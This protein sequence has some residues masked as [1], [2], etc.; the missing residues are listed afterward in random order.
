MPVA[1]IA[2]PHSPIVSFRIATSLLGAFNNQQVAI[3]A[4]YKDKFACMRCKP[5]R[6]HYSGL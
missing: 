1:M 4:C 3:I 2:P 6:L 5:T